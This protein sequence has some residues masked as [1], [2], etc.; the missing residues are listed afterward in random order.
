MSSNTLTDVKVVKIVKV[1]ENPYL[2]VSAQFLRK[3][4]RKQVM[5]TKLKNIINGSALDKTFLAGESFEFADVE[6]RKAQ[7][8]Y[9]DAD[10]GYF[11]QEDT[12]ETFQVPLD[13]LEDMLK[14]ILEGQPVF[15][16]FYED[17]PVGVQVPAKVELKIVETPPGVRGDTATGGSKPATMETG[18]VI[19]VPFFINQGDKIRIN[20]ETEEY[21]ERVS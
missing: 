20:T 1:G 8:L 2:I 4:Q 19:Q 15:V 9:K 18:I 12:Y 17:R 7:Y 21:C 5:K 11:M 6:N 10:F 16:V 3:Q 14:Y 13:A